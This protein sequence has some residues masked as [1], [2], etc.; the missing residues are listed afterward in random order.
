VVTVL[1]VKTSFYSNLKMTRRPRAIEVLQADI[2]EVPGVVA[3]VEMPDVDFGVACGAGNVLFSYLALF[4]AEHAEDQ[5]AGAK[6]GVVPCC[7]FSKAGVAARDDDSLPVK[8]AG[9]VAGRDKELAEEETHGRGEE[10][11]EM[12]KWR[13]SRD[14]YLEGCGGL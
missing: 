6:A 4:K 8:V 5:L 11:R 10:A 14:E 9:G 1:L 3:H 2:S 12:L 7:F 13:S